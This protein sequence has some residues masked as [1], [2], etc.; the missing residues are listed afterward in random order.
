MANVDARATFLLG[1]MGQQRTTQGVEGE[2]TERWSTL[3][4]MVTEEEE[5]EGMEK[6]PVEGK[7]RG[8]IY[9]KVGGHRGIVKYGIRHQLM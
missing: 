6:V 1:S 2:V 5:E 8:Y 7:E 3:K 9:G 4:D